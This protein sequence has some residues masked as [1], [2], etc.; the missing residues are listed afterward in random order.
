MIASKNEFKIL[1]THDPEDSF[2]DRQ[3]R[4]DWWSQEKLR[5][6]KV[7][8]VG[9][10]AIGNE[11]L[12]NLALLGVGNIFIADFDKISK[13]NLSRTVLFGRKDIGKK[14]AEIAAKAT[15]KLCLEDEANVDW[16]HGDV[17]WEL[18]VGIFRQ[19]DLVLGCLDNIEARICL[20]YTSP[21]PRD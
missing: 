9:A 18:G 11:V 13:S 16:F 3:Q 12:K 1:E 17:V 21:S 15:K 6:A 2:Y 20:L 8:V 10:G 19:M 14:K 5:K 4:I 7:M